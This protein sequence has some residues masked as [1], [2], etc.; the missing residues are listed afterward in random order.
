[1]SSVGEKIV[2]LQLQI[3]SDDRF[4]YLSKLQTVNIDTSFKNSIYN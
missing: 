4:Y 2:M 1:M 3:K